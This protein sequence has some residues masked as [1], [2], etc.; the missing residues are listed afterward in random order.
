AI[1]MTNDATSN[2]IQVYDSSTHALRQTLSTQ[3]KGNVAGN[4]RG[5][6]QYKGTLVAAVNNGSNTV[7]LFRRQNDGLKF[8]RLVTTSSAPVSIDFGNDH[9]YVAGA[10]T[11]DSFVIHESTVGWLDGTTSLQLAAGGLPS[12]G[13]TAQVGVVNDHRLLVTLKTDPDPGTVDLV[14]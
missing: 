14:A 5:V 3:G 8:E 10:T 12:P 13:S 6:R 1:I 11:V 9:M 2:A 4:A 7:A